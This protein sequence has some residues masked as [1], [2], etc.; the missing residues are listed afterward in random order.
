[1]AAPAIEHVGHELQFALLTQYEAAYDPPFAIREA[2][3]AEMPVID[4]S[5]STRRARP[6]CAGSAMRSSAR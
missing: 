6:I 4:L 1:M 3:P 2:T 5:D